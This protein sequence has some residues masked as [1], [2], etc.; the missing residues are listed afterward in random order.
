MILSIKVKKMKTSEKKSYSFSSFELERIRSTRQGFTLVELLVIVSILGILASIIL[1]N[2][3]GARTKAKDNAAFTEITSTQSLAFKCL[4][5]GMTNV[6]LLSPN[7]A[8][9][10][11]CYS[12]GVL[13]G[14]PDWKDLD[15]ANGWT[16]TN[17]FYWCAVGYSGDT[18]P[19]S[20]AYADG[21]CGGSNSDG[22]FCYRVRSGTA[23]PVKN[24][25][26]TENGCKKSGF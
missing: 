16:Y 4:T 11:F 6:R 19:A 7:S 26:C 25:W 5:S 2:L 18:V 20:C 1:V 9:N 10:G 8:L 12:G 23:A 15:S 21:T 3:N 22:R 17:N 24:I 13:A 14:W